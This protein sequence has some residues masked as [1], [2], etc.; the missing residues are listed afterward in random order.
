[1]RALSLVVSENTRRSG[2]CGLTTAPVKKALD[3]VGCQ[4]F[5]PAYSQKLIIYST[6]TLE[7]SFRA[8][9][10]AQ[11]TESLSEQIL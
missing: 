6:Y 4:G 10:E 2:V 3:T 11:S 9:D 1:M 5:V 7:Y 8:T